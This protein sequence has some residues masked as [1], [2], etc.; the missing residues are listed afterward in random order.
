MSAPDVLDAAS[1]WHFIELRDIDGNVMRRVPITLTEFE[2]LSLRQFT[3]RLGCAR[4]PGDPA[5][6]VSKACT[7]CR[8]TGT[9]GSA[10]RGHA[11]PICKGTGRK[12]I[13][14]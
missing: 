14:P 6:L 5:S 13:T 8:A 1:W 3:T 10:E 2:A 4:R 11:C 9:V 12:E 7:L